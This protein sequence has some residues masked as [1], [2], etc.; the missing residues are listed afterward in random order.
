MHLAPNALG[1]INYGN[2]ANYSLALQR[3]DETLTDHPRGADAKS[4]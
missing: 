2:L 3:F 4:G 1:L